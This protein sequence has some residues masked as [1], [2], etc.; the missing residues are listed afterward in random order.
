M[1]ASIQGVALL[2]A[3]SLPKHAERSMQ[4]LLVRLLI[5]SLSLKKGPNR[6]LQKI[7]Y[8]TLT[9]IVQTKSAR[10]AFSDFLGSYSLGDL[11]TQNFISRTLSDNRRLYHEILCEFVF[12][13]V[14]THRNSHTA[15]FVFLYRALERVS[16][17]IPLL[18]CSRSRDYYNTFRDMKALFSD[19]GDGELGLLKKFIGQRQFVDDIK[20][21][22]IYDVQFDGTYS[23]EYFNV[24]KKYCE[25]AENI[26]SNLKKFSVQYQH[27]LDWF[28]SIRNRF[29][30]SKTG[31][32]NFNIKG[33]ELNDPDEFFGQINPIF[34]SF[35][36]VIVLHSISHKYRN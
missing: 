20:L 12:Y 7:D 6:I 31:D 24:G 3:S 21:Q 8:S 11:K 26:D 30:H 25:K 16:F 17:S 35:L 22:V 13:F 9:P 36:S 2:P 33:S 4:Y 14:Q 29:F 5:G 10:D 34:C 27:V 23:S 32:I 28:V 15:A 18:Y 1:G 19:V